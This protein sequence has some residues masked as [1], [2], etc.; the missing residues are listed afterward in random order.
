[1]ILSRIG[2]CR[3]LIIDMSVELPVRKAR[4]PNRRS[5]RRRVGTHVQIM[6]T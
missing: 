3:L 6:L 1:M 4:G 5:I 2:F